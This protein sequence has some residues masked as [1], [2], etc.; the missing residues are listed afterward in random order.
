MRHCR[1]V[2]AL[3]SI[4]LK[5]SEGGE[6]VQD[7]PAENT[8]SDGAKPT[9]VP[10]PV[11]G[12]TGPAA[13]GLPAASA[14]AP[15][16][17]GLLQQIRNIVQ[18]VSG[19]GIDIP[20]E[21]G[22][23]ASSSMEAFKAFTKASP[24]SGEL[25]E[26]DLKGLDQQLAGLQS[27][28]N[29][30]D[31]AQ[32]A[33]F[34]MQLLRV[35]PLPLLSRRA[36]EIRE[37]FRTIFGETRYQAYLASKPPEPAT[38][39]RSLLIA[40]LQMLMKGIS[41]AYIFALGRENEIQHIK[42]HILKWSTVAWAVAISVWV[43]MLAI[44]SPYHMLPLLALFGLF[45]SAISIFRRLQALAGTNAAAL[46]PALELM[47]LRL[48]RI[49]VVAAL[50]SGWVFAI[51]IAYALQAQFVDLGDLVPKF[52]D[53]GI[54]EPKTNVDK[55]KLLVLAFVAGFAERFVPDMIDRLTVKAA[56]K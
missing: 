13:V 39:D 31:F 7:N 8:G 50:L 51:L 6:V 36:W 41:E 4:W 9:S 53:T 19:N 42:R 1:G 16:S 10:S 38:T 54:L 49:G 18:S 14:G 22:V 26:A 37:R 29:K 20:A 46:D 45:G 55:A 56:G 12:A 28:P 5:M 48:G 47:S 17:E 52:S 27:D 11:D 21:A 30:L 35:M 15:P 43:L 24:A 44:H 23:L 33:R 34:E 2:E 32:Y 40:D 3:G 25:S